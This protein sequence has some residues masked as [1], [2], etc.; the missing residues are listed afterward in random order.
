MDNIFPFPTTEWGFGEE[1]FLEEDEFPE[2]L[3]RSVPVDARFRSAQRGLYIPQQ[4]ETAIY[5]GWDDS[6][7]RLVALVCGGGFA[8]VV[9]IVVAIA[10]AL[11]Q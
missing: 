1:E 2:Q 11:C 10:L 6:H 3:V 8:L 4:R 7:A 9:A 5:I